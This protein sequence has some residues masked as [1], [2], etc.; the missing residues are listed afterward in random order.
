MSEAT[1]SASTR[2]PRAD[3]ARAVTALL[4]ASSFARFLAV[5][6]LNTAFGYAVFYG[7]LAAS[8]NSLLALVVSTIV[9]VLFNFFSIGSLVFASTDPRRLMR[10]FGVYGVVFVVDALALRLLEALGVG[11]ALAQAMLLPGLAIL[12]YLLNKNLVFLDRTHAG[13]AK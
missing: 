7:A 9:G 10:F 8:R 5:G 4:R 12:S 2:T 3:R 11:S 6:V 13:Q 1:H